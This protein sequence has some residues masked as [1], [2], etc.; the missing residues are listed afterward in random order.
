MTI[1]ATI[2]S[3]MI[4]KINGRRL[5]GATCDASVDDDVSKLN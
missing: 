1:L 5:G 3:A 2:T 4:E